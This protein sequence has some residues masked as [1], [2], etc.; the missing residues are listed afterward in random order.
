MAGTAKNLTNT[1]TIWNPC[2]IWT[3]CSAPAPG[4]KPTLHTDGTPDATANPTAKHGGI[5]KGN[6][7][8]SYKSTYREATSH[9]LTAPHRRRRSAETVRAEGQWAKVLDTDILDAFVDGVTVSTVS[10]GKLV[11]GG[12][13]R[14]I[15]STCAYLIAERVDS[16]GKYLCLVILDGV[17]TEGLEITFDQENENGSP[18]G[19][20]GNAVPSRADGKNLFMFYIDDPAS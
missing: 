11:E 18:F 5:L 16:P 6:V 8:W 9:Q 13:K 12:G 17:F 15:S 19:I 4:S 3:G 1:H 14:D 2:D 10:G 20:S 7:K